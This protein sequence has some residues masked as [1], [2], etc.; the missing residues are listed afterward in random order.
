MGGMSAA[1]YY[2]GVIADLAGNGEYKNVSKTGSYV[3]FFPILVG[4]AMLIADL[5]KPGQFWH[6]LFQNGPLNKGFIFQAGSAMSLG[7]W[8]LEGF[9]LICGIIYPLM[10]LAEEKGAGGTPLIPALAGK[11]GLR[12]SIGLV[13]LPFA[14]LIA[15]YTGVLLAATSRP[16]WADTPLLPALFTVSAT[17]T[18]MA[19]ITLLM[20]LGKND[21]HLVVARLEK[22]DSLLIKLELALVAVLFA[23]LLFSPRAAGLVQDLVFG[24]YAVLFWIGFILAGLVLPLAIQRINP[25]L[26]QPARSL[27]VVSSVL[28]LLG[29]FFLRYVILLAA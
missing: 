7:A 15:V 5:G 1:A 13:G 23:A 22:G 26:G 27:A 28:V 6:L 19:A 14:V 8:I 21:N 18:G 2:I 10:W 17:S 12:R 24:N 16:V 29:G 20:S 11:P 9:V 4:M 25:N 3:V